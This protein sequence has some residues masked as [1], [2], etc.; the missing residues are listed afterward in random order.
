MLRSGLGFGQV[1]T[2]PKPCLGHI[3][4]RRVLSFYHGFKYVD[5]SILRWLTHIR[6]QSMSIAACVTPL[7]FLFKAFTVFTPNFSLNLKHTDKLADLKTQ[8][9]IQRKVNRNRNSI[10]F[11]CFFTYIIKTGL[12]L[13]TQRI[14]CFRGGLLFLVLFIFQERVYCLFN[15]VCILW[16]WKGNT[17]LC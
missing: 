6:A 8:L 17:K 7:L 11:V 3:V 12:G 9:N 5:I 2:C 14:H 4:L 13:D 16:I 1:W 15:T 10:L